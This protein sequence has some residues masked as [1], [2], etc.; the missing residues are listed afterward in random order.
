[1]KGAP[2][3]MQLDFCISFAQE[4]PPPFAARTVLGRWLRPLNMTT[5]DEKDTGGDYCE[6]VHG[7]GEAVQLAHEVEAER[8]SPWTPDML[9][10]YI[11]LGCAYLCGCL[12]CEPPPLPHGH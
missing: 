8:V 2:V 3:G 1:M 9:R 10:L 7:V 5:A 11:V 6:D 12:V 4:R